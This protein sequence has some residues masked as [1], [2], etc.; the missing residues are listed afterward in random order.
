MCGEGGGREGGG[1]KGGADWGRGEG[2]GGKRGGLASLRFS[3]SWT[4]NVAPM[5]LLCRGLSLPFV[6]DLAVTKPV[7]PS[8]SSNLSLV[9][10]FATRFANLPIGLECSQHYPVCV[11][12]SSECRCT[13]N[14][15]EYRIVQVPCLLSTLH[16][17]VDRRWSR[18]IFLGKELF[19]LPHLSL[20]N[21]CNTLRWEIGHCSTCFFVHVHRLSGL[22]SLVVFLLLCSFSFLLVLS[23]SNSTASISFIL[24]ISSNLPC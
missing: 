6:P 2:G 1:R 18:W 20:S 19:H 11:G 13:H 14:V 8:A 4:T 7:H 3:L 24:R 15:A 21:R 12:S 23:S 5:V 22:S 17:P 9:S 10:A 16:C